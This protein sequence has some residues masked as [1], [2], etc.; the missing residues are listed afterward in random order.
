MAHLGVLLR[1]EVLEAWR[2][3]RLPI[4][5]GLFLLVGLSSPL[6]ARYLPEIVEAA[7]GDTLGGAIAIPTPTAADAV[8]QLLKNLSQFGAI[9]AILL[10][11]GSVASEIERGTAAF[12]LARPVGRGAF[13]AAKAVS[14][15]LVLAVSVGLAVAIGWVYTAILFEPQPPGGWIALAVMTWLALCAWA[16][17]TFAASAVTGS[18]LAAGGLG[19]VGLLV[20]SVVAVI[21]A[22]ARLTPAGLAAPA[23]ALAT[24]SAT[25]AELGV[26]LWVPI[27][28]TSALIAVAL[29]IAHVA[30]ARREL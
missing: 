16:A 11:M 2:T 24:G 9:A 1:K 10:A 29:A 28:A 12:V 13:L 14:I 5:A 30:F 27:L 18:G 21:P 22:I 25:A 3:Y 7:A 15:G 4:V 6:L 26:D 8:D 19:F 17:L 20:L 23:T